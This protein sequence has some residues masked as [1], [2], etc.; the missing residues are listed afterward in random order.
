VG[1]CIRAA[2][3]TERSAISQA[4]GPYLSDM[5]SCIRAAKVT[6][7]SAISQAVGPYLCYVGSCIR[8]AK[9]TER[10]AIVRKFSPPSL[11]PFFPCPPLT[12]SH[13]YAIIIL[14]AILYILQGIPS[15]RNPARDFQLL[16]LSASKSAIALATAGSLTA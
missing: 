6:E 16:K 10:S 5:G 13:L 7:R 14:E 9:V 4:V 1:S 12:I 8:A 15:I 2:K 3:V 11:I